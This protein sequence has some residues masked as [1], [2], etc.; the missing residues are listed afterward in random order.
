MKEALAVLE[1]LLLLGNSPEGRVALAKLVGMNNPKAA[2]VRKALASLP[3]LRPPK[4]A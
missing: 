3:P 1:Q 4:E 2:D